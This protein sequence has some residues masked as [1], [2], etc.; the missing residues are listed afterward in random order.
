MPD[1]TCRPGRIKLF[2]TTEIIRSVCSE[3]YIQNI[4]VKQRIIQRSIKRSKTIFFYFLSWQ[5]IHCIGIRHQIRIFKTFSITRIFRNRHSWITGHRVISVTFFKN[6]FGFLATNLST[7]QNRKT[8]YFPVDIGITQLTAQTVTWIVGIGLRYRRIR[9]RTIPLG[10]EIQTVNKRSV[11]IF[12]FIIIAFI[13]RKRIRSQTRKFELLKKRIIEVK[14]GRYWKIISFTFSF[15]H[16]PQ[17]IK[18][19]GRDSGI[20]TPVH[21]G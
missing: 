6:T 8:V 5:L 18:T 9:P 19:I 20:I 15:I 2:I 16:L 1:S 7:C 21:F 11:S 10:I 4:P 3:R 13:V 12:P 17:H 14:T